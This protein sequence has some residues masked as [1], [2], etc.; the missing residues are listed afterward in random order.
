MTHQ[1]HTVNDSWSH[2]GYHHVMVGDPIGTSVDLDV[3]AVPDRRRPGRRDDVSPE[4]IPLLRGNAP[5]NLSVLESNEPGQLSIS[6]GMALALY[7]SATVWVLLGFVVLIL[8]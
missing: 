1:Y 5:P 6:R 2:Y 4:L 8:L 7:V 3:G